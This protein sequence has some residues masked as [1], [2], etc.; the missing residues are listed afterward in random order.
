MSELWFEAVKNQDEKRID[1]LLKG[2]WFRTAI[3]IN[4]RN[5]DGD[6]ALIAAIKDNKLRMVEFLIK[7]GADLNS[8]DKDGNTPLILA[9]RRGNTDMMAYLLS[10]AAD[11][12]VRNNEGYS[13]VEMAVI[14]GL[15]V[16]PI[17]STYFLHTLV[18]YGVD[19]TGVNEKG[20]NLFALMNNEKVQ[21]DSWLEIMRYLV[22]HG[23]NVNTPIA[24][25]PTPLMSVVQSGNYDLAK[26]MLDNGADINVVHSDGWSPVMYAVQLSGISS[27]GN[28][29]M[30]LLLKYN[31]DLNLKNDKGEPI[32]FK[33][34][35]YKHIRNLKQFGLDLNMQDANGDTLLMREYK[36]FSSD[37]G[38]CAMLLSNGTDP[39][40]Q[41][42]DG[43][44]ALMIAASQKAFEKVKLMLN[45]DVNPNLQN[46]NGETALMIAAKSRDEQSFKCLI[47]SGKCDITIRDMTGRTVRDYVTVSIL[48]YM[49]SLMLSKQTGTKSANPVPVTF[50]MP[51]EKPK[52]PSE[53]RKRDALYRKIE[54][55][56]TDEILALS[57]KDATFVQQLVTTGLVLDV[58]KKMT[59]NDT[60]KL[61]KKAQKIMSRE[62]QERAR[63]IIRQKR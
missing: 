19:I 59:Y 16:W 12:T 24:H 35:D 42:N 27:R 17:I 36:R 55:M 37:M 11:V 6:T 61:F 50:L 8:T 21:D 62:V 25:G 39:N 13:A 5:A 44:T 1:K 53:I 9:I 34:S 18:Q 49:D 33:L 7:R 46:N 3:D 48:H 30:D 45:Y 38:K 58:L 43:E 32:F 41:N 57:E 20:E 28:K 54:P 63:D 31:P 22:D 26:H 10:G 29:M 4:V 47:D 52:S 15:S 2:A 40:I 14:K 23:V 56:S 60:K 51:D